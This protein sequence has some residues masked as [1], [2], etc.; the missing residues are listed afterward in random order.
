MRN[1]AEIQSTGFTA[2]LRVEEEGMIVLEREIKLA[3]QDIRV[4]HVSEMKAGPVMFVIQLRG[5]CRLIYKE[6]LK[7]K[8][9]SG[10]VK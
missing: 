9:D 8:Y 5:V 2:P 7:A 1:Q 4:E 10:T 6:F 3:R